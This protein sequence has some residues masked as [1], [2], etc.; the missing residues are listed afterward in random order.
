MGT[1]LPPRKRKRKLPC[2]VNALACENRIRIDTTTE[3]NKSQMGLGIGTDQVP[4]PEMPLALAPETTAVPKLTVVGV[5][6][7]PVPS[8]L[9]R[10]IPHAIRAPGL[11]DLEIVR[12]LCGNRDLKFG[13]LIYLTKYGTL[14]PGRPS[15]SCL[16]R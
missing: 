2:L 9:T 16:N 8:W 7:S 6:S 10:C 3:Q 14:C 12:I 11:G 5:D 4:A 1:G 15:D 13:V